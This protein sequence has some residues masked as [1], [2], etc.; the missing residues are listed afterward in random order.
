MK[1]KYRFLFIGILTVS[2]YACTK[3]EDKS[4]LSTTSNIGPALPVQAFDYLSNPLLNTGGFG[5][6]LQLTNNTITLGRVLFYDKALSF[7][8]SISC[9]SCHFQDKGFAD[10]VRFHKGVFGNT[11]KRNTMAITGNG[12][13]MFWDG[14]ASDMQ[15]LVLKPIANHDEM[16]QDPNAL[17]NKIKQLS[18]YKELFKKAYNSENVD[19][20]GIE[21]ALAAFCVAIL[22]S[23]TKFDAGVSSL[24]SP[25]FMNSLVDST[26]SL[27]NL[28]AQ[29]NKGLALFFGKAR[30]ASCHHPDQGGSTYG[31]FSSTNFANIGLDLTYNDNGVGALINISAQ[32]GVFKIPNLKNV[33]LTAPYMH[34][35]RFN[36]LEE[37]VEHYNSGIKANTNLNP[38]LFKNKLTEFELFQLEEQNGSQNLGP[39][40]PV[41]LG[42][43][44]DEKTALVA[45]LKTLTDEQL[46]KDIKFSNPF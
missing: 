3:K 12:A 35:G 41:R 30:C 33:A 44:P 17:I 5:F 34:D 19:L 18:Y 4:A 28:T 14:R 7:N 40:V 22:P 10:D 27:F 23:N 15:D 20:K 38:R 37:V 36:T 25:P 31:S 32:N 43:S 6:N 11:L 9:G 1:T 16:V 24:V 26:T 45:F 8:N 2:I 39:V 29:E 42:L 46:A 13:A 21:N